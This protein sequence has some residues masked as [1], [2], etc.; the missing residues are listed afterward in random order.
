MPNIDT[1][2]HFLSIK[3]SSN[4]LCR[5][6][7]VKILEIASRLCGSYGDVDDAKLLKKYVLLCKIVESRNIVDDD[8]FIKKFIND[9]CVKVDDSIHVRADLL[10]DSFVN[11][12][13][14]NDVAIISKVRFGRVFGLYFNRKKSNKIL[15][16]GVQLKEATIVTHKVGQ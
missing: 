7:R 14:F 10:Y 11:W 2:L 1:N 8:L 9:K 4:N 3:A 5:S 16:I 6:S 12:C 13:R 15:Y